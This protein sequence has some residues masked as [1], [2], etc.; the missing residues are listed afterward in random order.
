MQSGKLA[1]LERRM[2]GD[3]VTPSVGRL[4]WIGRQGNDKH[5]LMPLLLSA[6]KQLPINFSGSRVYKLLRHS[7]QL[8]KEYGL[9]RSKMNTKPVLRECDLILGKKLTA[10]VPRAKKECKASDVLAVLSLHLFG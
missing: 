6:S 3:C 8:S 2:S 1:K 7:K 4:S 5:S 10:F 9:I